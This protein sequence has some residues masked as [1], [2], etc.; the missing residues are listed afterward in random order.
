MLAKTFVLLATLASAVIAAPPAPVPTKPCKPTTTKIGSVVTPTLPVTG[1]APELPAPAAG[2]VLK[3][4]AIGHGIQ[5]YSCVTANGSATATGALAVLYDIQSLYPGTPRTGLSAEAFNG[6]STA[7]LWGQNLPLNLKN[8][9]AASPGTPGKPNAL[10]ESAYGADT[11][12]P[13]P[14]PAD[15]RLGAITVPFLGVHY[16]DAVSSPTFDLRSKAGL[17]ASVKKVDVA[18]APATADKGILKTGAVD[19]LGL[20]DNGR[21]LGVGVSY[22]YRVVTA[23]GVAQACSTSGT[24]V[25]SVPY[26][27]QYW[28]YGAA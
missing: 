28:F 3:A 19:W 5:N 2:L 9:T 23:G 15:L 22:V 8:K 4:L 26:A 17:L 24:G 18:K 14:A 21:G 12:N 1:V 25:G 13:F 7:I 20:P 6:L 10:A 16:F 11:A 27:A